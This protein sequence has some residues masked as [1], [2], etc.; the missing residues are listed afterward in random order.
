[1]SALSRV[2]SRCVLAV[3]AFITAAPVWAV[4]PS[5]S[6]LVTT[7]FGP[8]AVEYLFADPGEGNPQVPATFA[9]TYVGGDPLTA[10]GPVTII[11]ENGFLNHAGSLSNNYSTAFTST[12]FSGNQ[13]FANISPSVGGVGFYVGSLNGATTSLTIDVYTSLGHDTY[14]D[15]AIPQAIFPFGTFTTDKY[16]F[17]GFTSSGLITRV[18]FAQNAPSGAEDFVMGSVVVTSVPEPSLPMML[19]VGLGL[20]GMVMRR[21]T[22]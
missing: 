19:V 21:K 12:G 5:F 18:I 16:G 13:I 8:P 2:A 1:M 20:I 9:P 17:I 4:G 6:T 3:A 14:T 10:A 22:A 15:V 7:P 11:S